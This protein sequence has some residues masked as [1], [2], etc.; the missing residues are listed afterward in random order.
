MFVVVVV[1]VVLHDSWHAYDEDVHETHILHG[2][3][4]QV[5]CV[6]HGG[7]VQNC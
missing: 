7:H 4:A 6:G 1:L 5:A 2:Y 3:M